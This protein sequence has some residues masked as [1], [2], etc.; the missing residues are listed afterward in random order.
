ME[1]KG[2]WQRTGKAVAIH[3]YTWFCR[4]WDRVNAL[5]RRGTARTHMGSP[6][7]EKGQTTTTSYHRP[8]DFRLLE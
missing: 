5:T 6:L 7:F 2:Q 1:V 3:A 8:F 4:A